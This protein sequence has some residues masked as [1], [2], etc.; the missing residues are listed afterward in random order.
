M[1]IALSSMTMSQSNLGQQVE[2]ALTKKVMDVSED[3]SIALIKMMEMSANPNLGATLD[4][5]V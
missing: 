3:N 1:D 4:I 2:I 5:R